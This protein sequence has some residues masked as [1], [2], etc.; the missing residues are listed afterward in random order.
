MIGFHLR[1]C[2]SK[3][4]ENFLKYSTLGAH[5]AHIML[6]MFFR[7]KKNEG[8]FEHFTYPDISDEP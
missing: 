5:S 2:S 7:N 8:T 6:K 4:V 1:P 3:S